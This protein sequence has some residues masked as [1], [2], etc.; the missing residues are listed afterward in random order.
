M[1]IRAKANWLIVG[2]V[3][4]L[5]VISI[6]LMII[7]PSLWPWAVLL[8]VL[9]L[10]S[11]FL[12][13]KNWKK[14]NIQFS[15]DSRGIVI[16]GSKEGIADPDYL[17][18]SDIEKVKYAGGRIIIVTNEGKSVHLKGL[19]KKKDIIIKEIRQHI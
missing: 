1:V 6:H 2:Q 7:K 9:M 14:R 4:I 13:Y 12:L 11:G 3:V 5:S 10:L 18:F 17:L 15:S 19:A 16:A 8:E